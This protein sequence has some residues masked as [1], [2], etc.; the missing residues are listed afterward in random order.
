MSASNMSHERELAQAEREVALADAALRADLERI[1][2]HAAKVG[3]YSAPLGLVGGIVAFKVIRR[4]MRQRPKPSAMLGGTAPAKAGIAALLLRVGLPSIV[5]FV[6]EHAAGWQPGAAD[7]SGFAGPGGDPGRPDARHRSVDVLPRVSAS[8][9]RARFAGRWFEAGRLQPSVPRDATDQGSGRTS[10]VF[11]P[12][13]DGFDVHSSTT[14]SDVQGTPR[15]RTRDG[16]LRPTD[17]AG[18]PS[19]L[20]LSWAPSWSRWVP[21]VWS[22]YWILQVDIGYTFALVGDRARTELAVLSRS[23]SIEETAWRQLLA[24]A[25]EEG[26]PV[27]R[28]ER[29][30][31]PSS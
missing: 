16:V 10:L 14:M 12:V 3:S 7:R 2:A 11:V 24:T 30:G 20:S 31:F 27:E 5:G 25:A 23:P 13:P 9:D 21:M 28:L 8:L 26:Y 6:R 15:V 19:E 18:Q 29:T 4:A 17:P 1:K 22:D